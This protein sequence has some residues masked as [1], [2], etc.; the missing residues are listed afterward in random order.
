MPEWQPQTAEDRLIRRY[1]EQVG[2]ALYLEVPIGGGK[3]DAWPAKSKTR[4]I[5]A[6][7]LVGVND[8]GIARHSKESFAAALA[9]AHGVELIEVKVHLNRYLIGQAVAAV[10]MFERQYGR[11]TKAVL[12]CRQGDPALEWVCAKHDIEVRLIPEDANPEAH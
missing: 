8:S 9:L 3:G 5:D 6:V 10:D 12:L 4:R 1:F 7:R 11:P 2:G